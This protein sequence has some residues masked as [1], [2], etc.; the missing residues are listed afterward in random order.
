MTLTPTQ[1]RYVDQLLAII[2]SDDSKISNIKPS[3]WVEQNMVMEEPFPGLYKYSLTPYCREIID[4]FAPD[5]PMLWIAIMKGAQIGLSAGVIIPILLWS[6]VNDPCRIY[7]MVGSPD[8]VEKATEK[9]DK[10][11]DGAGIR[12]YI[13]SSIQRKRSMK[14]GDTNYKKDFPGGFIQ[15]DNPNNHSNLRDVS[16]RK[17]LF[18]DFEAVKNASK[19]AG[20]TRKML[21]QRFAAYEG[22]HKIAY[23]STPE[24]KATSN[25]EPAYEL[26]DCRKY[27]C[28]CPCCGEFIEWKWSVK[29]GDI[30]GGITW[31]LDEEGKLKPDSVGYKCQL[32]GGVFDDKN[33]FEMLNAGYWNPTKKPDKP[34][35]YSYHISALYA[36]L[37]MYGWEHY[38]NDWLEACP[39]NQ[40]RNEALYK[41]FVNVVLGETYEPI[42]EQ[43]NASKM[44]GTE[45]PYMP[46]ML[47]EKLSISDGNG[48]IILL[49]CAADMNGTEQDARIDYEIVAWTEKGASYSIDHGSIGTFVP[50]ENNVRNKAD[51]EHFTYEFN[52]PNSVWIEFDRIRTATYTTDTGREMKI[53]RTGLDCGYFSNNYAYPY[54]DRSNPFPLTYV[55]GLKGKGEDIYIMF[56]KDVRYFKPAQERPNLFILMVGRIKDELAEHMQLKW[57]PNEEHQP[58]GFMNFP[59]PTGGK[60]GQRNFFDHFESEHRVIESNADNT[61]IAACWKKKTSGSVNHQWDT[62]V[63]NIAVKE[64]VMEEY[65]KILKVPKLTWKEFVVAVTGGR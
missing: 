42:A 47:P 57:S 24:L 55:S 3:D 4:C 5:H 51:R 46:G 49:T 10:G 14:T 33:K 34:G 20:S 59:R 1:Q 61:G 21:E 36:P 48:R 60:Y 19:Q 62:R 29:V 11:I 58:F 17:G 63:Y 39:P 52:K 64:I 31:E 65:R 40:A 35:Y 18:D 54:I 37:G 26:G 53:Y 15:I 22:R 28:P 6:I 32:C 56:D 43:P 30:T 16:L 8:L 41:T 12:D 2:E 50:R 45:R 13:R 7:F 9:L 25:I 23:I 27:L 38:V 44:E